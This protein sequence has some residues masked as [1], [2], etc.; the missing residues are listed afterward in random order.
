MA[1]GA[2]VLR[3][4]G[5]K[6]DELQRR[7]GLPPRP[8]PFD[9]RAWE[10]RLANEL[11]GYARQP[12]DM[13][14]MTPEFEAAQQ[15]AT[16]DPLRRS[17]GI[18]RK[19]GIDASL[20][21][22]GPVGA[23]INANAGAEGEAVGQQASR[24]FLTNTEFG[25]DLASRKFGQSMDAANFQRGLYQNIRDTETAARA[26]RGGFGKFLK[27][28]AGLAGTAIGGAFGGPAGAAIG[29]SAANALV[30]NDSARNYAQDIGED[31]KKRNLGFS[32]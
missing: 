11:Y 12:L 18:A 29:G 16:I 28:V 7:F 8:A 30:G 32:F 17:F 14:F 21:T 24:N 10:Q 15:R 22:G 31:W 2:D 26:K 4:L 27:S 5:F 6:D 19:Q 3:R 9:E 25:A 1:N 20:R 13:S 23:F